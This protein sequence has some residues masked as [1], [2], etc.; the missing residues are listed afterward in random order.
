MTGLELIFGKDSYRTLT[1]DQMKGL[2][3]ALSTIKDREKN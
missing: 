3:Y 1:A 2:E